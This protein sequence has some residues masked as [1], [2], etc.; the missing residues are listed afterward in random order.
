MTATEDLEH[1]LNDDIQTNLSK[2]LNSSNKRSNSDVEIDSL[3][4]ICTRRQSP[5]PMQD[6]T[7]A[8]EVDPDL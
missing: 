5:T 1:S 3:R 6:S 7:S 4:F 2:D 8:E